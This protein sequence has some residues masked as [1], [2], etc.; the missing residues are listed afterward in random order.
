MLLILIHNISIL[1]Y[2]LYVYDCKG[3]YTAGSKV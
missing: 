3:K 2:M 1:Y